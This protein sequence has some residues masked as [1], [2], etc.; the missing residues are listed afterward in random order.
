MQKDEAVRLLKSQSPDAFLPKARKRGWICPVC[1]NG[2]G[3]DGDGI[4][5][6]K[7]TAGSYKCFRCGFSGDILDLI[8]QKFG[9]TEF[10]DQLTKASEIYPIAVRKCRPLPEHRQAAEAIQ[11]VTAVS[12][13]GDLSAYF[14]KCHEAV[15]NTSYF[16]GRGISGALLDRFH[17]G[18]D[19][20]FSDRAITAFF[21]PSASFTSLSLGSWY[22]PASSPADD[23]NGIFLFF[24]SSASFNSN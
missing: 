15:K 7:K 3:R 1:G 17:I 16:T 6:N 20:A 13:A 18:Y 22:A 4:V 8:G 11:T 9:L 12:S 24:S 5:L 14:D 21:S 19:E 2:E 23:K 10:N